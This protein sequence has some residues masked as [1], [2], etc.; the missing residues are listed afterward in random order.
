MEELGAFAMPEWFLLKQSLGISSIWCR[1]DLGSDLFNRRSPLHG[2]GV[3]WKITLTFRL[4]LCG[5][6]DFSE[7][8]SHTV[9]PVEG[10]L[11]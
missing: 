3:I 8:A 9:E 4:R 11:D 10:V 1:M 5:R 6:G 7:L 2:R